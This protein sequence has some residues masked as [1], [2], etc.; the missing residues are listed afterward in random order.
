MGCVVREGGASGVSLGISLKTPRA[1]V[2]ESAHRPALR[3]LVYKGSLIWLKSTGFRMVQCNF[4]MQL[5]GGI[6]SPPFPLTQNNFLME[7]SY[8]H[9]PCWQGNDIV[10]PGGAC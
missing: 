3:V 5:L 10:F 9:D 7:S 6:A 2:A 4:M 8:C 1:T